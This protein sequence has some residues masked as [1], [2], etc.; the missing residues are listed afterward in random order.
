LHYIGY[1]AGMKTSSIPAVRVEAEL[2]DQLEQVLHEGESLSSFVEA[3]V[4]ESVRRRV[5]Q[6]EFIAR[7]LASLEAAKRSGRYIPADQVVAGLQERL[8]KARRKA[9]RKSAR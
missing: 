1:D 4:R 8:D 6:A 2:R 5:E 9:S 3:S 7:G